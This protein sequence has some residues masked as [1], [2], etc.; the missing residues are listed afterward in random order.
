MAIV[1]KLKYDSL[2]NNRAKVHHTLNDRGSFPAEPQALDLYIPDSERDKIKEHVGT[3]NPLYKALDKITVSG[4]EY[5]MSDHTYEYINRFKVCDIAIASLGSG[6]LLS[7]NNNLWGRWRTSNPASI[8]VS[9]N[10]FL[11]PSEKSFSFGYSHDY[12]SAWEKLT[13]GGLLSKVQQASEAMR[14]IA[15]MMGDSGGAVAG[16]FIPRFVNAPSWNKTNP[17][18]LSSSLKF[19]FKFGQAGLFSGEEEVVRPILALA[20]LLA[21]LQAGPDNYFRGPVPTPPTYLMNFLSKV[22]DMVGNIFDEITSDTDGKEGTF[23]GGL[24]G[25]LTNIENDLIRGQNQAIQDTLNGT[26]DAGGGSRGLFVRMGRMSWGP[27]LVKDI[28]WDFNFEQVDEYGFPYQGSITFS[29]LESVVIPTVGDFARS[30][31]GTTGDGT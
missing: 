26:G 31:D 27:A 25:K 12:G 9:P 15:M 16:R 4:T 24:V 1:T 14:S 20:S 10:V 21:P 6:A 17:L 30:F 2:F 11:F 5:N 13:S 23:F 18:K 28:N 8:I 3:D 29:G 22:P 19:E 7:L